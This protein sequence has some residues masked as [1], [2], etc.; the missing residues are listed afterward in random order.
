MNEEFPYGGVVYG[1]NDSVAAIWVP[2]TFD[3]NASNSAVFLVGGV[4]GDGYQDQ[5][6]NQVDILIS[7]MS[8]YGNFH[9]TLPAN[10]CFVVEKFCE[11]QISYELTFQIPNLFLLIQYALIWSAKLTCN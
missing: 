3:G 2:E 9:H 8:V 11:R 6:T 10:E 4:W 7:V 1:Y 5:G